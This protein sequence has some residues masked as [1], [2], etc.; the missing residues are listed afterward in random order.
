LVG[1][2]S[3]NYIEIPNINTIKI[4]E[5]FDVEASSNVSELHWSTNDKDVLSIESSSGKIKGVSKG[6]AMVTVRSSTGLEDSCLIL[7]K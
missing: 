3:Q 1:Y 5:T 4:G 2:S 7:V 6:L